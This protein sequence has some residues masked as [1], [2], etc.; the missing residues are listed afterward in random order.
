[1]PCLMQLYAKE[2]YR[3]HGKG[4]DLEVGKMCMLFTFKQLVVLIEK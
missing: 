4:I 1:M 3:Y 2:I